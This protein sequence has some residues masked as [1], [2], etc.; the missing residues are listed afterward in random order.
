MAELLSTSGVNVA[1]LDTTKN[2]NSYYIYTKNEEALRET[3]SH[4]LQGL[5]K[6]IAEG[7]QVHQNLTVYTSLPDE[8]EEIIHTDKILE[9]LLKN[10]SLILIDTDFDTPARYF[11]QSQEIY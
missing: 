1:I 3:A 9:T 11:E 8:T 6:G 7:I 4:S 2:R 5:V 10:H